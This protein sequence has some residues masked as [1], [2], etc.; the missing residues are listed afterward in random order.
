MLRTSEQDGCMRLGLGNDE[1]LTTVLLDRWDHMPS[2]SRARL[3][4]AQGAVSGESA[5]E[6]P[7]GGP[8]LAAG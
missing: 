6:L 2:S 4:D 8:K 1:K 5:A 7:T 3:R